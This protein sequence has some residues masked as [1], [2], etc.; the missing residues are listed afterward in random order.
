MGVIFVKPDMRTRTLK[1]GADTPFPKLTAAH[2]S[3]AVTTTVSI[4]LLSISFFFLLTSGFLSE[5][6]ASAADILTSI[7]RFTCGAD[8]RGT[9]DASTNTCTLGTQ[10]LPA[11]TD[12]GV[13]QG[14]TAVVPAGITVEILYGRTLLGDSGGVFKIES[15]GVVNIDHGVIALNGGSL[16]I[17]NNGTLS[18]LGYDGI[19]GVGS[20]NNSGTIM[21]G[22]SG[23]FIDGGV[24][25]FSGSIT[26]SGIILVQGS[27]NYGLRYEGTLA[28]SGT[29]IV[30]NTS[31]HGIYI[32]Q[33]SLTNTGMI[34]LENTGKSGIYVSAA[35]I[36]NYGTITVKNGWGT[37]IN[38]FSTINNYGTINVNAGGKIWNPG[39]I[40]VFCGANLNLNGGT[41]NGSGPVIYNSPCYTLPKTK[42]ALQLASPTASVSLWP[43]ASSS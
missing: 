13:D 21:V 9:W 39:E 38:N 31:G 3:N 27:N 4:A 10:I 11:R 32:R 37:G 24:I 29:L 1:L 41:I 12:W 14:V 34:T 17:N 33:G 23:S 8:I 7:D 19:D 22:R 28:N 43:S 20:I 25:G 30:K 36:N 35:T 6:E 26:N 2:P 16:N 18:V 5:Q 15:G 40:I 42:T